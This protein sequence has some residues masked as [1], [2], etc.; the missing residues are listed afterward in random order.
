MRD[1]A[2][3]THIGAYRAATE[4]EARRL[5]LA[6]P[7]RPVAGST[8]RLSHVGHV[9]AVEGQPQL[10]EVEPGQWRWWTP[11]RVANDRER[12][13]HTAGEALRAEIDAWEQAAVDWY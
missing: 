1:A 3:S 10:V 5:A 8:V 4:T 7:E 6:D 9:L 11:L 13:A 12:L 2:L